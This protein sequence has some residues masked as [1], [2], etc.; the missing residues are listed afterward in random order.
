MAAL[1]VVALAAPMLAAC[2]SD[3]RR[4]IIPDWAV[5]AIGSVGLARALMVGAFPDAVFGGLLCI[6]LGSLAALSGV[7]GWGDAKLLGAAGLVSGLSAMP[8]LIL[9][10]AVSGGLLAAMLLLL[11]A[12]IRARRLALPAGAPRWLRA[13]QTRLRRAPSVPYG[14][15]IVAGLLFA[16]LS[17]A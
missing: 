16:L 2:I 13:E 1:V 5:L 6:A 10:A 17:G 15:A 9:G 14:L 4:R 11:R 7:W 12:P 8:A 3:V